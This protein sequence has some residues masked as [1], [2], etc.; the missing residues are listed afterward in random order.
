M[1]FFYA[2]FIMNFVIAKTFMRNFLIEKT[3]RFHCLKT[4]LSC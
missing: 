2:S 1:N 3:L 4:L